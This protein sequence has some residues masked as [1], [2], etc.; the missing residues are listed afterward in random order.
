MPADLEPSDSRV[1]RTKKTK[2]PS[3]AIMRQ[4]WRISAEQMGTP[5]FSLPA[6]LG[7]S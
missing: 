2:H 3:S 6:Y 1:Y 7:A 4:H 5:F